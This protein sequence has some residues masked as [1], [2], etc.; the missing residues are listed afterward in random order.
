MEDSGA[1]ATIKIYPNSHHSFDELTGMGIRKVDHAY[2]VKDCRVTLGDDGIIYTEN[3]GFPMS[4]PAL[5]KIGLYF[6]AERGSHWGGNDTTRVEAESDA[7]EFMSTHL[8]KK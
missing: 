6:C 1:K 4:S 3:Y 7:R 8:L 5:Q 2:S